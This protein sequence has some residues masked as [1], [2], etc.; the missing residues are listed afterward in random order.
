[1]AHK[2]EAFGKVALG[3]LELSYYTLIASFVKELEEGVF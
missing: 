3:L 1:L 2:E